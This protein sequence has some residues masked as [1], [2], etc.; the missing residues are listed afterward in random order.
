MIEAIAVIVLLLLAAG[1]LFLRS[2]LLNK[3]ILSDKLNV[4]LKVD[5]KT[6]DKSAYDSF[7]EVVSLAQL[8]VGGKHRVDLTITWNPEFFSEPTDSKAP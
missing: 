7:D 1:L 2:K 6:V 8:H 4:T 3:S 5:G